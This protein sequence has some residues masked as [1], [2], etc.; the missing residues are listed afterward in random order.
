[1]IIKMKSGLRLLRGALLLSTSV[2]GLTAEAY[3][4]VQAPRGQNPSSPAQPA[5][6]SADIGLEE[7]IVTAQ[8]RA[9][10]LSDVPVSIT[11][12]TGAQLVDKG[13]NDIQDLV[14]V[15][16]GLSFAD[17]GKSAPVFS[18]RGV[19]FFEN[20]FGG[21]PTVSVYIDEAPLPFSIEAKAAAFDL[22]RVEVLK[23]PQGTLF[24]QSSTG[25]AINYIAAKPTNDFQAGVTGSYGRFNTTDLQA[26]VSG[27]LSP[28]LNARIAVHTQQG[29][30]WQQ[31]YTREDSIGSQNFS[32]ARLLL[33]WKPTDRFIVHLN[34]NGFYDGSDNQAPQFIG[35]FKSRPYT[36]LLLTYPVAPQNPRAADWNIGQDFP[37]KN[38]FYQGILRADYTVSD[39]LTLTSLTS[40][41]HEDV[42]SYISDGTTLNNFNVL[43][44]GSVGSVSEEIRASGDL[45]RL[46]YLVG[47]NYQHDK[48]D[49]AQET[50]TA[51][52]TSTRIAGDDD[53]A[54]GNQKFST[55]AAFADATYR[56]AERLRLTGGIRY[57]KQDLDYD[58]CLAV[59]D[60]SSAATYTA[61]LNS[62]R[63]K[64]GLGPIAPLEVGQCASLDAT[65]SPA[66]ATGTLNED[67]VSWRAGID[68][69]PTPR[70]LTYFNVSKGYKGGSIP[71]PGA[72]STEQ[73]RPVTQESVLA[74]EAGIKSSVIDRVLDFTAAGFYYDYKDK[75]LLGR[76]VFTPNIF[77]A[78][79]ALVNIPKSRILGAEWQLTLRPVI[80]MTLSAAGTYLDTKVMGDF[81]NYSLL[82]VKTNFNGSAFPYTPKWQLVFDGEERIPISS[83]LVGT[84]AGNASYRAATVAGFGGDPRLNI[85]SYWLLD[86][87]LGVEAPDGKWKAHLYGRNILNQYYWNNV[88]AGGDTLRRYAGMPAT[89]GVQ[90]SYRF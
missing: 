8:K 41:S 39:L 27:P 51:Y 86:L 62:I 17:S 37:R 24:G 25:G 90:M 82:G 12:L 78:Q 47:G 49:E 57:T 42:N 19:G 48:T 16:P 33:D 53:A 64:A 29:D 61:T 58:G 7:I 87:R 13:I 32:Q 35:A 5:V 72:S 30:D 11:A 77:G 40:Y 71:D 56:L 18:L 63:A 80:G 65:Y 31:S 10:S 59:M 79:S 73:F 85:D 88:S 68:F 89:Y 34:V 81:F 23:G 36:P 3:A 6:S 52:A 4:Q 66:R 60:Q 2:L 70:T 44:T 21:R 50:L 45:G 43:D 84:F 46:H 69:K 1:M 75:Q 22:E 83:S 55:S 38:K 74:F 26:N 76:N 28:T 9:Q 67:N 14:K 20:A 54:L 15:T